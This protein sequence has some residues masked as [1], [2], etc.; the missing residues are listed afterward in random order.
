MQHEMGT[1]LISLKS[2]L[3]TRR[4]ARAK[5]SQDRQRE[6]NPKQRMAVALRKRKLFTLRRAPWA[7]LIDSFSVPRSS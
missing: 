2:L 1:F 5:R 4:G 3:E 7:T 6:L